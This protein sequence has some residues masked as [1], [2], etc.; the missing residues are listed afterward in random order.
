M[1]LANRDRIREIAASCNAPAIALTGSTARGEDTADSD[2]DFLAD[3][4][5]E[6]SYFDVA[7]MTARAR[8]PARLRSRYRLTSRPSAAHGACHHRSPAS[9]SR[10]DNERIED[11]LRA[12]RRG[13]P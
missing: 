5:D 7:R 6:T 13:R 12:P 1:V 8:R 2:C 4:T 11:I 9:V 10:S 3:Y